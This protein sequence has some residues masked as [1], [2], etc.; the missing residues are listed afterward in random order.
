MDNFERTMTELQN[1]DIGAL[2]KLYTEIVKK[3]YSISVCAGKNMTHSESEEVSTDTKKWMRDCLVGLTGQLEVCTREADIKRVILENTEDKALRELI[4]EQFAMEKET[5]L[6]P[7]T[8]VLAALT[9]YMGIYNSHSEIAE[10]YRR[11]QPA[12]EEQNT[13]NGLY[14][15]AGNHEDADGEM[16]V[17]KK[18]RLSA[19]M[20]L[21]V[22][23][24]T[25]MFIVAMVVGEIY[26]H[27]RQEERPKLHEEFENS[28][29]TTG[30]ILQ[31]YFNEI[32]FPAALND[33]ASTE[34]QFTWR[35]TEAD[36]KQ[37]FWDNY[38]ECPIEIAYTTEE[39]D[40]GC[41]Y[42]YDE[43][44]TDTEEE[45]ISITCATGAYSSKYVEGVAF[46][47]TTGEKEGIEEEQQ[48]FYELMGLQEYGEKLKQLGREEP[49]SIH[50]DT[51]N[52]RGTYIVEQT[53][54]PVQQGYHLYINVYF[55][56]DPIL[57]KNIDIAGS[58]P[59]DIDDMLSPDSYHF[60]PLPDTGD[61]QNY[62][63]QLYHMIYG[64]R[65]TITYADRHTFYE[66]GE[67][68]DEEE[69]YLRCQRELNGDVEALSSAGIGISLEAG[70]LDIVIDCHMGY[71][72]EINENLKQYPYADTGS[73]FSI[74]GLEDADD[75]F[76][77]ESDEVGYIVDNAQ[78]IFYLLNADLNFSEE[79]IR[80]NL[81]QNSRAYAFDMTYLS[82]T[83]EDCD[84]QVGISEYMIEIKVTRK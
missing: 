10:C 83:I 59:A 28:E 71:A 11:R 53:F 14:T 75:A 56:A 48:K 46:H 68:C 39:Y 45:S 69:L 49:E 33:D 74:S 78:R 23:S 63:S 15:A 7:D 20:I 67:E 8:Q 5:Q 18:R 62:L 13:G 1:G 66:D 30:M 84:Y 61:E 82:K 19:K 79:K 52:H 34:F 73:S 36:V 51:Q 54:T 26:L 17:S 40:T 72:K 50:I 22:S 37:W 38:G 4:A 32:T 16:S 58:K 41:R 6:E 27:K 81:K 35:L 65:G 64:Y 25:L 60:Q 2:W 57:M 9:L 55:Y 70:V 76:Y 21:A 77:M 24:V 42:I 80:Q 43:T 29:K 31:E 12:E 44:R 3:L 47:Y